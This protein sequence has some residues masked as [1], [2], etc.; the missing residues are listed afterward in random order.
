MA[1]MLEMRAIEPQV[2]I[3]A[4]LAPPD[5]PI[6]T[7][8]R[9]TRELSVHR[10][11][12]VPISQSIPQSLLVAVAVAVVAEVAAEVVQV[13]QAVVVVVPAVVVVATLHKTVLTPAVAAVQE[14]VAAVAEMVVAAVKEQMVVR[15]VAVAEPL[16]S[17]FKVSCKSANPTLMQAVARDIKAKED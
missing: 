11:K 15:E 12:A 5:Q 17:L 14:L 7:A 2:R 10:V 16:K 13:D 6:K 8:A 4:T 1:A 9:A 3:V